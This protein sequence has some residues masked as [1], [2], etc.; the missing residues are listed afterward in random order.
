MLK[1]IGLDNFKSFYH[2]NTTSIK[3]ITILCGTNSSGKSSVIKSLL[4]LKQSWESDHSLNSLALNGKYTKNGKYIDVNHMKIGNK[5]RFENNFQVSY[6][7]TTA[8]NQRDNFSLILLNKIFSKSEISKDKKIDR[9]YSKFDIQYIAEF[10][11]A[12]NH[13][14][15]IRGNNDSILTKIEVKIEF[16]YRKKKIKTLTLELKFNGGNNRFGYS[17]KYSNMPTSRGYLDDTFKQVNC[18]FSGLQLTNITDLGK[19]DDRFYTVLPSILTIFQVIGEQYSSISYIGPLREE[20]KRM[21]I[22]DE[23]VEGVGVK[24]EFAPMVYT[25]SDFR[26]YQMPSASPKDFLNFSYQDISFQEAVNYWLNYLDIDQVEIGKNEEIIRLLMENGIKDGVN[27]ADVGF[28]ISQ[29][30]PIIV[31]A[32]RISKG[33]TL[34][35]EQPEIHLHPKMQMKLAD[36]FIAM[37]NFDR[38]LIVETHSDHMINRLVRRIMEDETQSLKEM[39]GIY[40]ITQ[41]ENKSLINEIEIDPVLGIVDWPKDFFD[42][43]TDETDLIMKTGFKNNKKIIEKKLASSV[44]NTTCRED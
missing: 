16:I 6:G 38:K 4:A 33:S 7:P 19:D 8:K 42:Q 10:D 20:P 37:C 13:N 22:F 26:I 17:L 40:Y 15:H 39:I 21:Y 18:F 23:A 32:L 25:S 28:G 3:P 43:Y 9:R 12:N 44:E 27:I 1:S 31:E 14:I 30:F 34:M 24:G 36:F 41:N 35:L 5:I 29:T 11:S 2:L